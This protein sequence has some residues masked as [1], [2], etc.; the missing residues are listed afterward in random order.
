M[1]LRTGAATDVGRQRTSNEDTLLCKPE[2]GV[3]AVIDGVGGYAGGEVAAALAREAIS[4]RL[5]HQTGQPEQDLRE[6]V[7]NANNKIYWQSQED[8]KLAH[9]AC[10]LTVA[11]VA[12]D[13]LVAAHVGDTRL[14]KIRNQDIEKLT[15]DHSF[16]GV[17][18]DEQSLSEEEAMRH[19]RRN[20]ILRDVGS[21]LHEPNDDHFI[22]IVEATF[23]PDAALLLCSDG[24]TDLVPSRTLTRL[25]YEHA[26]H[27]QAATEALIQAA[28]EAGGTDNITV[29]VVEGV[30]FGT[31]TAG[32]SSVPGSLPA[33]GDTGIRPR[34]VPPATNPPRPSDAT[35]ARPLAPRA[36]PPTPSRPHPSSAEPPPSPAPP[37]WRYFGFG[38]LSVLALLAAA[39]VAWRL[40][41]AATTPDTPVAPLDSTATINER[42]AQARPGSSV[43]VAPGYY[44][45]TIYL[46]D[47]VLLI[48]TTPGGAYLAPSPGDSV[49]VV[50]E[51]I[52]NAA[53]VGFR[54]GPDTLQTRRLST[55]IQIRHASVRIEGVTL[56][57]TLQ[58]GIDLETDALTPALIQQNQINGGAG[59]GILVR[60]G[61]AQVQITGNTIQTNGGTGILLLPGSTAL[62]QNNTLNGAGTGI[63][64]R[65]DP[66]AYQ[67]MLR[68]SNIFNLE[69]PADSHA[70]VR[71]LP[72]TTSSSQ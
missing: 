49:A 28:N 50:A 20:E 40:W 26:G 7:T 36:A 32:G 51:H 27:P 43:E 64:R 56:D 17:Q 65:L 33:N 46:R 48:S 60:S 13:R 35:P 53:L 18:E 37:R 68:Q 12:E 45:E 11:I 6:A 4:R 59:I 9:M 29:I 30:A 31:H 8:V 55:G 38:V 44:T 72:G 67:T 5:D 25:V 2:I 19:P 57:S 15:R 70:V 39:Y 34:Y 42:L 21:D 63:E 14:Y 71:V 23:E 16:V 3:F 54:I 22:E 10:V 62:V 52:T 69:T 58:A 61:G 24:L 41:P 1:P 66:G 47:D